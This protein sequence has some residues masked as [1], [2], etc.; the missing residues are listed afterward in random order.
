MG[1]SLGC[2]QFKKVFSIPEELSP[3]TRRAM[4]MQ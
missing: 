3:Q 1:E 4:V 2:E